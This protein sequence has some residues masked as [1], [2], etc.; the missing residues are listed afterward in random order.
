MNH[1]H[2]WLHLFALLAIA[3]AA[4]AGTAIAAL[5]NGGN[6]RIILVG[7]SIT[8]LSRNMG[9]V[10]FA[11][12][13]EWALKQAYPGAQPDIVALGGSGQGV[14][15]WLGV[16]K[17]S[18]TQPTFLDVPRIDAHVELGKPADV[19][20]IMLGMNDV[21]APYVSEDPASIEGWARSYAALID[22]LRERVKPKLVAL[23]TATM[24]TEDPAS[25]KN[26]MMDLLN[27]RV[28]QLAKEKDCTLLPVAAEYR[29]VLEE[30]RKRK[31]D[32]HVTYDFV[33]PNEAGHLAIAHAM[34]LG[35]GEDKAAARLFDERE[36]ALAKKT[37][38]DKPQLSYS[39]T[40]VPGPLASDRQAFRVCCWWP[41]PAGRSPTRAPF[42]I[43]PPEGWD[44]KPVV[45]GADE[46]VVTGT[47]D[48]R[49][50]VLVLEAKSA[51]ALRTEIR[52]P[53]P[54]LVAAK[55]I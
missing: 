33:H 21:L 29:R 39:V 19:V 9:A 5:P 18:R 44:A 10:G 49:E 54:W 16:E 2:S 32:F 37:I 14:G 28:A 30:G 40:P 53:P 15:S 22:A 23:A 45:A 27:A 47:P 41:G 20:I 42:T 4:S 1:R 36:A 50:N 7:D 46:F 43:T 55:L 24:N 38:G 52:I 34:L 25:P 6:T 11:F 51:P 8:G 48:R 31:P 17:G 12:Q 35:L 3:V 26:K 13:M